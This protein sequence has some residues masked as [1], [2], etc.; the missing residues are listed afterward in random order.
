MTHYEGATAP[1]VAPSPRL[2]ASRGLAVV[3][4]TTLA[5]L[6]GHAGTAHAAAPGLVA[7]Y[8]FDEGTGT[9]TADRSGHKHSATL[10][11]AS[12]T[13]GQFGKAVAFNG[14]SSIA[15]VPDAADLDFSSGM[16]VEAWI[17]PAAGSTGAQTI[18]SKTRAGG[19]FPYGL[20]LN[21]GR[22]TGFARTGSSAKVAQ[23]TTNVADGA[24]RFVATTYDG[25]RL[26]VYVNSANVADVAATG[27][28]PASP[29]ALEIGADSAWGEHFKGA[30]DN[31]RVYPR[32][33]SASELAADRTTDAATDTTAAAPAPTPTPTPS[34]SPT[35][36]PTPTPSPSPTPSPTPT[37]TG[38]NNCMP[39]PSACGFPD[40]E[41]TGV[42]PQVA[43]QTVNGNVTLSTAGQVYQDKTV[44]GSI[45]VQANNVTIRNVKVNGGQ[46]FIHWGSTYTGLVVE[47]TEINLGGNLDSRGI[48]YGNY[49]ARRVFIHNGS[50]CAQL[51][52]NVTITDSLCVVGPDTNN[53]AQ[54]DN[55]SF[56]NGPEHWDG[57]ESDGGSNYVLNHNT[58]RNPCDQTSGILMSTNVAA[59]KQVTITNN[60]M[61]GGGYT[62]YCNAGPNVPSEVVTGNRFARSFWTKSGYWGPTTGCNMAD[63]YSN[64]VWDD[65]GATLAAG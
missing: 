13:T 50:D 47:D 16:T 55:T 20:E 8:S 6:C 23:S 26:R 22:P 7:S 49:T 9:T 65:T 5:A 42:D 32:A 34:P 39:N 35:P 57:L 54:P 45:T 3:L 46:I 11:A 28:I 10:T 29:D 4:A 19:G 14:S 43:R 60:L 52:Y 62:L 2:R 41:N 38:G 15:R 44:N 30:I 27:T 64:N 59:I 61:G 33:L 12:W 40:L 17:K 63:T 24:W 21:G 53:D 1:A 36:S 51:D 56:C 25:A 48:L 58:I 31:V 18:A 37:P